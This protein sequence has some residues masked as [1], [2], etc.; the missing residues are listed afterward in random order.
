MWLCTCGNGELDTF[1]TDEKL[2]PEF[3][4]V[5]E[6]P[7]WEYFGLYDNDQA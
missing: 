1:D 5:C 2:P 7:L 3:C 6:F 4:D